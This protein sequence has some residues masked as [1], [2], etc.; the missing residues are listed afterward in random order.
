MAG[1]VMQ[2][3]GSGATDKEPNGNARP[4]VGLFG[5]LVNLI[6]GGRG[7]G[8]MNGNV[9]TNDNG[10]NTNDNGAGN[11]NDNGAGNANNDGP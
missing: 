6:S 11:T 9:N 10:G 2:A 1:C 4:A 8:N 5:G 3:D 7:S